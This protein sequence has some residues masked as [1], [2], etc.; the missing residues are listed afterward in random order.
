MS[1]WLLWASTSVSAAGY[2]TV[3]ATWE[4]GFCIRKDLAF[5]SSLCCKK[6]QKTNTQQQTGV[7]VRFPIDSYSCSSFT[8]HM[9]KLEF[10]ICAGAAGLLER[11]AGGCLPSG[12][13]F[14]SM[15][16]HNKPWKLGCMKIISCCRVKTCCEYGRRM[17]DFILR[18][19]LKPAFIHT[20]SDILQ[21]WLHH[22]LV[23]LCSIFP[24]L[25]PLSPRFLPCTRNPTIIP[26]AAVTSLSSSGW[27]GESALLV[28][29][30]SSEEGV[31]G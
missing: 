8:A 31:R 1:S 25:P 21:P 30:S 28:P 11:S 15:S 12:C 4:M 17:S 9:Q 23:S 5:G 19:T 27:E 29:T 18:R 26:S 14:H 16:V 10:R 13:S 7:G 2:R 6:K 24:H 20:E 3:C 22:L